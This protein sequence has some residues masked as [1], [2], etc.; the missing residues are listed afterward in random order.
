MFFKDQIHACK[1][2]SEEP[3]HFFSTLRESEALWVDEVEERVA[4]VLHTFQ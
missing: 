2:H 4:L 1:V 3:P